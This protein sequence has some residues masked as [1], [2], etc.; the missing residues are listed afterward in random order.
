MLHC[1]YRHTVPLK[2]REAYSF[3]NGSDLTHPGPWNPT[4]ETGDDRRGVEQFLSLGGQTGYLDLD[5]Q[6]GTLKLSGERWETWIREAESQIGPKR[7]IGSCLGVL[8]GGVFDDP[9]AVRKKKGRK[10]V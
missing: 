8:G 4:G 3:P 7:R 1:L 2:S 5:M 6:I 9:A 10:C